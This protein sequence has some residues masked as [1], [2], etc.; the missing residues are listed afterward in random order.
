MKSW[1]LS[2]LLL[3][4]AAA[5]AADPSGLIP[6]VEKA[7]G[8]LPAGG[9][10]I[11]QVD[12][13]RVSYAATGAVA[14]QAGL[15]PEQIEFEIGSITKLFTGLLLAQ[16]TVEGKASPYDPIAKWLPTDL[17]LDPK[18]GAITLA[19]LST[20]TS[21]L[22]SLPTNFQP[23]NLSDPYADYDVAK[24]YAFLQSYHP[25]APA[26]QPADYS[27]VGVGLL[28]HIL[29]RIYGESYADLVREKITGPL[30][31]HDTVIDLSPD[32][33]ARFAVPHSGGMAVSPWALD[34]LAGAGAL[35][36]TAADLV[37]FVRAL[38]QPGG[39]LAR[40]W[41]IARQPRAPFGRSGHIG[42]GFMIASR[43]GHDVYNHSG[44]TGGFRSYLEFVPDTGQATILLLNNDTIEPATI[45]MAL[46]RKPEQRLKD[47]AQTITTEE[48]PAYTGV[49]AI[50]D[51][52]RFTVLIHKGQLLIRLTGQPFHPVTYGGHDLFFA[53]SVGAEFR[54]AR[55]PD[56]HVASVTLHQHG[57][58]T[59]A[60]RTGDAPQLLFPDTTTLEA[61]VGTY[62]LTPQI[63]FEMHVR[64]GCL[65]V[66]LTGQ[67][68]FPVFCTA[69]D[70]FVY[71]VVEASL[72]FERDASGTVTAVV[73]H[74][75]GRDMRAPR[76]EK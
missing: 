54:F 63:V 40:A 18:V 23:A 64:H 60:R 68:T 58:D 42:L 71:D 59:P 56:G 52:A 19:Q 24:L 53:K 49:Y 15:P 45:V 25:A 8:T 41:A 36:S 44:G 28:G 32:Q 69:P 3:T 10:V 17:Q 37:K 27:N 29:T 65:F 34:A 50:D 39:P 21:G 57:R 16:A 26:P 2:L 76:V 67:S 38:M 70:H 31:M 46:H 72:A 5:R 14:P 11:A 12:G 6:A 13:D 75:N 48:L 33:T 61:Y 7:A 35:R 30:G 20:H 51:R 62:Q 47:T 1:L 66:K 4:S 55:D 43:D 22:P 73:L 9:F 74:Q